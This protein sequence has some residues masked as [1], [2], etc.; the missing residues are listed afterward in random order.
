M[1]DRGSRA[2]A[3]AAAL[4]ITLLPAVVCAQGVPAATPA[5]VGVSDTRLNRLSSTM[6][7]YV[8]A[9]R[10]AGIVTLFMRQGKVVH[11]EAFGHRDVE[12]DAPMRTDSIFRIA[13][14]SKAVTS[15]AA[16][17]LLEEGRWRLD[18]P[19]TKFLPEFEG[20]K[21]FA[22]LQADGTMRVEDAARPPTMR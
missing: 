1:S 5:S 2:R 17:I 10:A 9:Q 16:M 11:L 8:D 6:Q 18:D 20:Q 21:V 14:M 15:V 3:F 13:S 12:S 22:G 19:I 7:Q 4:G